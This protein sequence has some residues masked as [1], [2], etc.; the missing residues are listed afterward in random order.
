M[1]WYSALLV[2]K[3]QSPSDPGFEKMLES[4]V[5]FKAPDF[6]GA[7]RIAIDLGGKRALRGGVRDDS[8]RVAISLT[9]CYVLNLDSIGSEIEGQ[10]VWSRLSKISALIAPELGRIPS[11]TI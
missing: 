4:L 2:F 7:H 10:E 8:G 11:Q 5:L 3:L 6:S 1:D 9:F